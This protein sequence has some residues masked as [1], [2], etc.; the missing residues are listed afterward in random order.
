MGT[1][2]TTLHARKIKQLVENVILCLDGDSA[3]ANATY[4]A[5]DTLKEV[6]LNVKVVRLTTA[7]DPDEY[8]K[9]FGKDKFLEEL[10][11]GQNCIDFVITDSAKK[12]DLSSNLDK[13]Q[14][15]NEALNYISKFSTPAEQEIYLGEVQKLVKV[16]IDALRKSLNKNTEVVVSKEQEAVVK[17]DNI[18]DNYIMESKI[19]LLASVLYKKTDKLSEISGLF[20]SNDELSNLYRFLVSKVE[21]N[22]D[23]NVSTLFDNFDISNGSLIDKVI[24]Y[25]F[26]N[27]EVLETYLNETIVRIKIYELEQKRE[28][29]KRKLPN[30]N[31]TEEQY[32]YLQEMQEIEKQIKRLKNG[33]N[34]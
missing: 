20:T 1:A 33:T 14:Y 4:K 6:G 28:E 29:I 7:K 25:V 2:L 8:I 26:P 16:P 34:W 18:K 11:S 30:C 27:D 31:S 3:G 21:L 23:Y 12:Y 22:K 24:N 10:Y 9:K 19:L 5:I 15:I 32:V 13:N 17:T